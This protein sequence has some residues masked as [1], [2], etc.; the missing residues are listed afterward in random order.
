MLIFGVAVGGCIEDIQRYTLNYKYEDYHGNDKVKFELKINGADNYTRQKI[1][2][3]LNRTDQNIVRHISSI[4]IARKIEDTPCE[5][6]A[7]GC[8]IGNFTIDGRLIESKI[9]VLDK[10][11]YKGTCNTFDRTF[12]HELGHVIYYYKFGGHDIKKED[13]IYQEILETYAEKY[14]D[15]YV[16][17][18]KEGCDNDIARQ[19]EKDLN[20]K[21]KIYQY[22]AKVLSKWDIYK[23][24]GIPTELYEEYRYDYELYSDAKKEYTDTL[25]KFKDYIRKSEI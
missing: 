23:Y 19:L 7:S 18:E 25:E 21:E 10:N 24:D 4:N 6:N 1:L 14:A 3:A 15:I 5:N 17:V 12:Y 16:R 13:K 22:S 20:E 9:Y 8:A 11:A 2:V